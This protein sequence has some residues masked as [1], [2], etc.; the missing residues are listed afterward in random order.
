MRWPKQWSRFAQT[1]RGLRA[2]DRIAAAAEQQNLL[3]ARLVEVFAPTFDPPKD[4]SSLQS[5]SGVSFSR[6][7]EQAEVQAFVEKV[8]A[9]TG[10]T[11]TEEEIAAHLDELAGKA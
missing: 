1:R 7:A 9:A 2:L 4:E 11:P 5:V 8:Y 3:L 10:H 6:D